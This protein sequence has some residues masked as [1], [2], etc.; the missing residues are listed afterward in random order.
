M[1]HI[2]FVLCILLVGVLHSS[3]DE[4]TQKSSVPEVVFVSRLPSAKKDFVYP[5]FDKDFQSSDHQGKKMKDACNNVVTQATLYKA[6]LEQTLS[7]SKPGIRLHGNTRRYYQDEVD[8]AE[9][10]IDILTEKGYSSNTVPSV[11][12]SRYTYE[13]AN[14]KIGLQHDKLYKA[15]SHAEKYLADHQGIQENILQKNKR[16]NEKN[17]TKLTPEGKK[18]VKKAKRLAKKTNRKLKKHH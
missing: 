4:I 18:K 11:S 10:I 2:L 3:C 14:D 9:K 5:N 6:M 1:K 17:L 13:V 15:S 8:R 12:M 7:M 16:K